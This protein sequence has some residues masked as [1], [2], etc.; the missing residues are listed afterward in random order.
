MVHG[1]AP[2]LTAF[3]HRC[4]TTDGCTYM[5]P[6]SYLILHQDILELKMNG[7]LVGLHFAGDILEF[8][9]SASQF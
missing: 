4:S 8:S 1:L 5:L 7:L 9:C 6:T 3:G 2:I